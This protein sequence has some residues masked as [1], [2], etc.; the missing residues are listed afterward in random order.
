MNKA[1]A[2]IGALECRLKIGQNRAENASRRLAAAAASSG[3]LRRWAR[4]F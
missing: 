2:S 3:S 1:N 4:P